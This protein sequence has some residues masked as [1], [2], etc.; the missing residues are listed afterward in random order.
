[1][2]ADDRR[3]LR[4]ALK[5]HESLT[6]GDRG[7]PSTLLPL[8]VWRDLLDAARRAALA[9]QRGWT[10][11]AGFARSAYRRLAVELSERAAA[12]AR[13]LDAEDRP[14]AV[15]SPREIL[16]DLDAL[17]AE[18]E[19]V[20]LNLR[21]KTLSVTTD[22]VVLEGVDLGRFRVE[23]HWDLPID[24]G[25]YAMVALEAN[26]AAEDD[27]VTHPH[28]RDEGLCE[29]D[30][31]TPIRR[32]LEEGRLFDF[33]LLVRQVL[34]TYN[35][36]SAYVPLSRWHGSRCG[37]CGYSADEDESTACDRCGEDLCL[38]CS[39]ACRDCGRTCCSECREP[40]GGCGHS[41]CP[42]CVAACRDC[43]EGFCRTCLAEARCGGCR[44]A[45][46]PS[47]EPDDTQPPREESDD[48]AQTFE[49]AADDED[50]EAA[51]VAGPHAAAGPAVHPL[52]L[53]EAAVS[54]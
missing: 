45:D 16:A 27:S 5:I 34:A 25:S 23:L 6:R 20:E 11:A 9:E 30:G 7:R 41:Y 10:A 15:Q 49:T 53:G 35:P 24:A 19:E 38:D 13:A 3:R 31:R 18:F 39:A 32:A 2:T 1:M 12:G 44:E 37:D 54:A 36:G 43:G 22:A 40:C 21:E 4:A 26:P 29:G 17:E 48:D 47:N 14:R 28:V 51:D 42:S 8:D 46:D 52:R 33:F 50:Q